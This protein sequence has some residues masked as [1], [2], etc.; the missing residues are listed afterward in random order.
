MLYRDENQIQLQGN[1]GQQYTVN[2]TVDNPPHAQ[3]QN[4]PQINMA[5]QM[6][7]NAVI[8]ETN[9]SDIETGESGEEDHD[10]SSE[11]FSLVSPFL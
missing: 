8:D 9:L 10:V 1:D 2:I 7:R 4:P 11:L 5:T 6:T 3:Q